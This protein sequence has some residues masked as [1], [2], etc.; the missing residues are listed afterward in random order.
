LPSG[1]HVTITDRS[2]GKELNRRR[3]GPVHLDVPAAGLYQPIHDFLNHLSQPTV[4][5]EKFGCI[6]EV[7]VP[8]G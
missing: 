5:K 6:E 8:R 7:E 1:E 4:L 2:S 3:Y